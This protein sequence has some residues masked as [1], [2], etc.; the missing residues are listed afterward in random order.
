MAKGGGRGK[1]RPRKVAIL[2][3]SEISAGILEV[4][5][6]SKGSESNGTVTSLMM[7]S[8]ESATTEE[9]STPTPEREPAL[10]QP[11]IPQPDPL[12]RKGMKLGYVA[13]TIKEGTPTTC[14]VKSELE[15]ENRKWRNAIILYVIGNSPTITYL[16]LFLR[17]Q[18]QIER[19]F[20]IFYHTD[21]YFVIR[22]VHEE[23]KERMMYEGPY[24]IASRPVIVKEW[25]MNFNFEK[26]ILKVIPLWIQL[27]NLPLNCWSE[28]S[29][30]RI[31]SIIGTPI[32]ADECTSLQK[33]ISYAR[34]L[35]E[36][37]VTQPLKYSLKIEGDNGV[38]V[39]QRVYYEWV[40]QFCQKC[41]KVGHI[42]KGKMEQ[43]E[44]K[45]PQKQWIRKETSTQTQSRKEAE[46]KI[47]E[48]EGDEWIQ[49]KKVVSP[50]I[51]VGNLHISTTNGYQLFQEE[52]E[53]LQGGDL[54]P[55]PPI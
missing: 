39:D 21:D 23:D 10:E 6:C 38:V 14:L 3:Q 37:D 18:C 5:E 4:G 8:E 50:T 1:G 16:T 11:V 32:C 43:K 54:F 17:R 27:P 26:E 42:C 52:Q 35:V 25:E 49:P 7:I 48:K 53:V 28:G 46:P 15:E 41:Q 29:L 13:P 47:I 40:P 45:V 44:E 19:N 12:R 31:G 33:R 22:F 30:S 20:D 9:K 55:F 2:A 36:V 24:S 34:M 51:Q